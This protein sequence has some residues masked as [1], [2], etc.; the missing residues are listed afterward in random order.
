MGARGLGRAAAAADDPGQALAK[1]RAA[2]IA[3]AQRGQSLAMQKRGD[4]ALDAFREALADYPA[5][6][7]A[8]HEVGVVL[9][10]RGDLPG[11]EANLRKALELAPDFERAQQALAE[12]LRREQRYDEALEHFG[13]ALRLDGRDTAAWYGA[14]EAL[15]AQKKPEESLWVMQQLLDAAGVKPGPPSPIDPTDPTAQPLSPLLAEVKKGVELALA[16]G[17]EARRWA[18]IDKAVAK[19]PDKSGLGPDGL[20]VHAGDADFRRQ[21]FMSALAAYKAQWAEKGGDKAAADA[22]LAYKIGATYAVINDPKQAIIWWRKALALDP[23]R[24]VIG[25]HLALLVAKQRASEMAAGG[26]ALGDAIVRARQA[27]LAGDPATALWLVRGSSTPAAAAIEGE[28]RLQLGDYLGARAIY[29]E[30]LG[31]DPEDH[32]AKGGLAEALLRGPPNPTAPGAPEKALSAW[33]GDDEVRT[34]TFLV[35]R[36]GE[37]M[38]RVL[39]PEPEE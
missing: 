11:A 35:L 20:P 9:A 1:K 30:L 19:A 26:P 29:E 27:L 10:E 38:A 12:V 7:L 31:E 13:Q 15:K 33:V 18:G 3:A 16:D 14:A 34:D 25:R 8:H 22:I 36:R 28:A 5:Y 23:S 6:P 37:V 21:A 2:A 39:N 17:V 24:E 4:E 32:V